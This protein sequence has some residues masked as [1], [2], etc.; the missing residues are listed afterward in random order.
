MMDIILQLMITGL[1]NGLI[2][3]LIALGYTMVYGIVE[4]INFAHGD[5]M[6]LGCFLALTVVGDGSQRRTIPPG[7]RLQLSPYA[8][9]AGAS[10]GFQMSRELVM[11]NLFKPGV[12]TAFSN[13]VDPDLTRFTLSEDGSTRQFDP[14]HQG[15]DVRQF[16]ERRQTG[17]APRPLCRFAALSPRAG[18]AEDAGR[19][20]HLH[21]RRGLLVA[22]RRG[23]AVRLGPEPNLR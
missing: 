13:D 2:I 18:G 4:L 1:A 17:S 19:M 15:C 5:V 7:A 21:R 22:R 12:A 16:A 14:D 11:T 20:P 10:A 6:M 9:P 3:A 8:I 23:P